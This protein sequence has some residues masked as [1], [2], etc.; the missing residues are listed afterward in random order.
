MSV[1]V[2]LIIEISVHP[3]KVFP[4][5]I[6]HF[7]ACDIFASDYWILAALIGGLD[8]FWITKEAK[9]ILN[10]N[11][12]SSMG[13]DFLLRTY[14]W[15]WL[16]IYHTTPYH[17]ENVCGFC[18]DFI[19]WFTRINNLLLNQSLFLCGLL[20]WKVLIFIFKADKYGIISLVL[21]LVWVWFGPAL[22]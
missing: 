20:F 7:R 12:G 6:I 8:I 11:G 16:D 10:Q 13:L 14:T 5:V 18:S 21:V 1:S 3:Y 4:F 9:K 19:V 15:L 22:Q 2:K 17:V